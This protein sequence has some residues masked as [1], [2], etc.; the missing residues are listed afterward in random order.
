M[1]FW[2]VDNSIVLKSKMKAQKK[3]ILGSNVDSKQQLVD[4]FFL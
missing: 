1:V 3:V 2:F 4:I